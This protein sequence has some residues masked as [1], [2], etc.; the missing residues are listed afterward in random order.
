MRN[1]QPV[2][3]TPTTFYAGDTNPFPYHSRPLVLDNAPPPTWGQRT[4]HAAHLFLIAV[5]QKFN[6]LLGFGVLLLV[7]LLL[8]RFLLH[9][10]ILSNSL[11]TQWTMQLTSPF[12][13]PFSGLLPMIPYDHYVIDASTLV[14]ILVYVVLLKL[15]TSFLN[16]LV[17]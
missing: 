3:D 13:Y 17:A 1:N 8:T 14:A 10:F 11:F 4:L 6:R 2:Q 9:F 16:M 5:V 7:L 15:V 12:I